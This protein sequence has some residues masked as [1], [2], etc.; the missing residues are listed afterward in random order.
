[1]ISAVGW[2][3]ASASVDRPVPQAD[4][5]D[6]GRRFAVESLADVGQSGQP[7]VDQETVEHDAVHVALPVA[8]IGVV[9]GVGDAVTGAEGV[10]HSGKRTHD[11][12]ISRAN[13]VTQSGLAVS[14]R[15]GPVPTTDAIGVCRANSE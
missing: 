15:M 2:A 5:G 10:E 11:P 7:L 14:I 8:E 3:R 6:P 1:M 13:G 4:V 9:L 12:D